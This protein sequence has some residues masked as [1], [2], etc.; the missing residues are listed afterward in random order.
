MKAWPALQPL[1]QAVDLEL[2]AA[3]LDAAQAAHATPPRAY[4][5]W[6]HALTVAEQVADVHQRLGWAQPREALLAALYHDA[7]YVPGRRDNEARSADLALAHIAAW[8]PDAGMDTHRVA[9]LIRWTARHGTVTEADLAAD[10]QPRD[11]AHFLDCDMAVLGADAATFDAY[12]RGI[13]AEYRGVLPQPLFRLNRRRFLKR[14][15]ASERIFLSDDVHARLDAAAR[16]NLRRVL[17]AK[18]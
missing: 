10:S 3:M 9:E 12:D 18:R 15:L 2:P 1:M 16:A 17:T 6:G 11:L 4:H 5:H 13:A 7:V 14:L 8:R